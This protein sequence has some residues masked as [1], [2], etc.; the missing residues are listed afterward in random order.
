MIFAKC[1]ACGHN[2]A[3]TWYDGKLFCDECVAGFGT[4]RMCEH[5][6]RCEFKTNPA[7]IPQFVIKHLRQETPNGYIEQIKE[8][9]NPERIKLCCLN[10]CICCKTCED[11][12]VRC[13]RQFGT[14]ENY[15]EIE[16]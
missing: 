5:S 9:P 13:L 14:C 11:E 12:K 3:K 15:K 2:G 8:S 1:A 10:K 6:R 16:F 7:P 4:C